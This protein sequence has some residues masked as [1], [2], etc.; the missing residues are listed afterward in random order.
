MDKITRDKARELRHHPTPQ[1][2]KLWQ[3]LRGRRL[4]GFRFRRQHPVGPYI[5]DFY[6]C[7]RR[8]AVELD[9]SQHSFPEHGERD[10]DRSQT[11]QAEGIRVLRFWNLDIDRRLQVVAEEIFRA[12]EEV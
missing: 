1:E 9:S 3:Y 12:L 10:S 8:L 5:L 6:C 11:L 7:E 2:R 4:G